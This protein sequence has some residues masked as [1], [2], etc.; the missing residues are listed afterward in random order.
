MSRVGKLPIE[1]P[2]G[3]EVNL[4]NGELTVKGPKGELKMN[5]HPNMK[6][7]IADGKITVT[8]PNEERENRALHGLTRT[9]IANMVKGVTDGFSKQLEIIGVGYKANVQGKKLVLNLGHSHPIDFQAPEGIEFSQ[10]EKNKNLLTVSGIDKQLVGET[11]AKIRSFRKPEPY[12]GK[13]VKYV[14]EYIKRKAGKTAASAS[15]GAA[16]AA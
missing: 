13:G 5:P 7:E 3:V 11:A 2:N 4:A 10:D 15:A 16:G 14:D 8:R 9:L 6:V 12:K 1:V